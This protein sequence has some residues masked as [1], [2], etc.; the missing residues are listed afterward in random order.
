MQGTTFA[1]TTL[2][3]NFVLST[4][5]WFLCKWLDSGWEH[6]LEGGVLISLFLYETLTTGLVKCTHSL[7][8][9]GI[10]NLI[11]VQ[12]V[13]G[14]ENFQF[15]IHTQFHSIVCRDYCWGQQV[16]AGEGGT[17]W[18]TLHWQHLGYKYTGMYVSIYLGVGGGGEFS[19]P[20]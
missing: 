3:M 7:W 16:Q 1:E 18:S 14:S 4:A 15:C 8:S 17:C 5:D 9:K 11:F 6:K 13:T 10:G 12:L 2:N 20:S 19:G